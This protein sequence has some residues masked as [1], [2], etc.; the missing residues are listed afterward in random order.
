[1]DP[2]QETASDPAAQQPEFGPGGYLPARAAQ[3]ARKIVLR[4]QMGLHWAVAAV[5]A[6][7]LILAITIPFV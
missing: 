4:E 5:V 2:E 7:L 1:M 6:G 3:R